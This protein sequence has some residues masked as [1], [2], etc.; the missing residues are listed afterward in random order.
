[1]GSVRLTEPS[2][3]AIES[4]TSYHDAQNEADKRDEEDDGQ[5]VQPFRLSVAILAFV[6]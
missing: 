4:R 6:S 1:M 5:Y 3:S 2:L